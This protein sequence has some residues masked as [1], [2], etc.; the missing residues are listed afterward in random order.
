MRA[1]RVFRRGP[2]A[3]SGAPPLDGS[4][5]VPLFSAVPARVPERVF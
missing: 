1:I 4:G 3:A 5:Q 2:T